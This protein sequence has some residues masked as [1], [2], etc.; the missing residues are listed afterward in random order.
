MEIFLE[1]IN[2][3]KFFCFVALFLAFSFLR[4]SQN[5]EDPLEKVTD[6]SWG[7]RAKELSQAID[8]QNYGKGGGALDRKSVV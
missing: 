2:K 4:A 8:A 3:R 7:N 6:D 1:F 5:W